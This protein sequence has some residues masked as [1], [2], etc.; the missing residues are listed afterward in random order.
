MRLSSVA[1]LEGGDADTLAEGEE[2]TLKNWGNVKIGKVEK[3]DEGELLN[4]VVVHG[5]FD[6]RS[7]LL[8][9]CLCSFRLAWSFAPNIKMTFNTLA[10]LS[11]NKFWV[12]MI[13]AKSCPEGHDWVKDSDIPKLFR[14]DY[15]T[16]TRA[17]KR[18]GPSAPFCPRGPQ[19][20]S[21][22]CPSIR[23]GSLMV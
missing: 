22:G 6:I 19:A 9:F 10:H 20:R 16:V 23:V 11:E 3:D 18:W 17:M 8:C 14:R 4:A 1:L 21:S 5:K 12:K 2:V 7:F 13:F 15:C